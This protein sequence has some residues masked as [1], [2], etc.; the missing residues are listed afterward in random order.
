MK[1]SSSSSR[2]TLRGLC[3]D[4]K[5]TGSKWV[6]AAGEG[7]SNFLLAGAP[8]APAEGLSEY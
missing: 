6:G 8:A 4:A 3:V 1:H 7:L 5:P 2:C